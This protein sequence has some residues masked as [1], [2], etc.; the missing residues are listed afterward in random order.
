MTK[1][2]I[3]TNTTKKNGTYHTDL[4]CPRL[5]QTTNFRPVSEGEINAHNMTECTYCVGDLAGRNGGDEWHTINAKLK[6]GE[7]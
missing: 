4:E 6:S 1:K 5:Q 7:L 2:Y 3:K